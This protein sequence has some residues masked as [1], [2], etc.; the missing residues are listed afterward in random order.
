MYRE[1][2]QGVLALVVAIVGL[3]A[4]QIISPVAW[5]LANREIQGIDQGSRNP[6]NRGTA[7]AAKVLGIIGTVLL[8][9]EVFAVITLVVLFAVSSSSSQS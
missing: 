9:L 3:V 5:V 2:S 8:V 7:V 1:P 4:F 6:A